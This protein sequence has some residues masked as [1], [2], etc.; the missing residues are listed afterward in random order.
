MIDAEPSPATGS[1][2]G[3]ED[4]KL[5]TLARSARAR[6]GTA[7]GAAVRD[8]TGRTYVAAPVALPSLRLSALGL[9]VAMA[10]SSGARSLAAA[11][12]VTSA[13]GLD[14]ADLVVL[15]EAGPAAVALVAAPDGSVRQVARP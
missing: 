1:E 14:P 7:E 5:V 4:L 2:P 3:P 9:A 15:R 6:A 10:M 8:E 12:L 13:A 11:A